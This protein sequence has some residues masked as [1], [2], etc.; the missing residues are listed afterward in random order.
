MDFGN[1]MEAKTQLTLEAEKLD[2][3]LIEIETKLGKTSSVRSQ[4]LCGG[5]GAGR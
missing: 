4:G 2:T 1:L 5:I 3:D